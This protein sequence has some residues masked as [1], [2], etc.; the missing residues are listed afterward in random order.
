MKRSKLKGG[1]ADYHRSIEEMLYARNLVNKILAKCKII[2][3]EVKQKVKRITEYGN[4]DKKASLSDTEFISQPNVLNKKYIIFKK[5]FSEN[6]YHYG[7][8]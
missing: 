4:S 6:N 7:F 5:Y 8:L 3:Q 1:F 2:S